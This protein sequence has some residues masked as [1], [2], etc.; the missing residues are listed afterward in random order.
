MSA[1]DP[2]RTLLAANLWIAVGI[3]VGLAIPVVIARAATVSGVVTG[4]LLAVGF[5]YLGGLPL[6]VPFAV[7]VVGGTAATRAGAKRKRALG[8][9][10]E[11]GGR[12]S[13]RHVLA[14]AGPAVAWFAVAAVLLLLGSGGPLTNTKWLL[15]SMCGSLTASFA[16]TAAGELGMLARATPRRLLFGVVVPRGTNGGMTWPGTLAG[17][18]AAIVG[19][20][21]W[22]VAARVSFSETFALKIPFYAAAIAAGGFAG[23]VIDSF[24][25]ATAEDR[26]RW[27]NETTNFVSSFLAGAVG[28]TVALALVP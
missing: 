9:A 7:L 16:D 17:F 14:N 12:R 24:I 4:C 15:P 13:A 1:A 2:H 23:S 20:G 18:G 26:L 5:T 28:G 3:G 21:A 8:V 11:G 6:L 19:A 25:G 22:G 10:Q 27:G